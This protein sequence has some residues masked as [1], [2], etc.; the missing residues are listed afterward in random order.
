MDNKPLVF[1]DIETTGMSPLNS[2]IL[3]IGAIRVENNK[4]TNTFKQLLTPKS[5]VPWFITKLT[6]ITNEMVW[7]APEFRSI[8]D[9][10]ELFLD[11]AIFVAHNVNFDY[12]FIEMEFNKIN[13]K[14]NMSKLCTVKLSRQLYPKQ[15][16]HNLDSIIR[17]H[18][19]KVA[20]RHRALDDALVLYEFYKIALRDH[21]QKTVNTCN[22]LLIN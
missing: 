7:D 15:Y 22:K 9:D 13:R 1:L 3:E 10:L 19:I 14:F 4:I 6:G 11:D 2:R 12:S 8:A 18:K 5:P 21:G 20:S 16:R 17:A